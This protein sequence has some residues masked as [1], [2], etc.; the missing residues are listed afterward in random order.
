M[1]LKAVAGQKLQD[2]KTIGSTLEFKPKSYSDF[3][4]HRV[5]QHLFSVFSPPLYIHIIQQS[6]F[7]YIFLNSQSTRIPAPQA[8]IR[9]SRSRNSLAFHANINSQEKYFLGLLLV[10]F[11]LLFFFGLKKN[12]YNCM[13]FF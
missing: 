11:F 10:H 8:V 4:F 13:H 7:A 1:T 12:L 3:F 5:Y 6:P 2:P 9:T